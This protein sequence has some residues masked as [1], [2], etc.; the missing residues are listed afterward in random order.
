MTKDERQAVAEVEALRLHKQ[1][2]GPVMEKE[3]STVA[4]QKRRAGFLDDEDFE[5]EV[6]S[7]GEKAPEPEPEGE[8]GGEDHGGK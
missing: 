7:E 6:V 5:D 3:G 1:R 4:N 2:V 8:S